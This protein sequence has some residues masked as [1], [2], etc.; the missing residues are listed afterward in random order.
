MPVSYRFVHKTPTGDS[1][2]VII[3]LVGTY[4]MDDLRHT[5]LNALADSSRPSDSPLLIDLSKSE[6]IAGRS[7]EEV[8]SMAQFI[9]TL[10]RQFNHRVAMVAPTDLSYGLMRMGSVGAEER[11]VMADVFRNFS[12]ARGW[13]LR[14]KTGS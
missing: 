2:I 4:S 9:G 5:I 13:L 1:G 14:T 6:S 10:G 12:E 7:T 8:K 11:G 3:D